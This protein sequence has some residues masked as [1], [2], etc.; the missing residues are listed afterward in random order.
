MKDYKTLQEVAEEKG[1]SYQT[2]RNWVDKGLPCKV[3]KLIGYKPR[4]VVRLCE[5]DKFIGEGI[6][7]VTE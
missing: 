3:E 5:V 1:V 7:E 6:D 2:V 4:M